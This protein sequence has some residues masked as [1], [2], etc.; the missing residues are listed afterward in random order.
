MRLV[1]I[2][3]L[4]LLIPT[5]ANAIDCDPLP[6]ADTLLRPGVIVLLGEIH[7][8]EQGP[9]LVSTLVCRTLKRGLPVNVGLEIPRI[10]AARVR[11]PEVSLRASVISI[12]PKRSIKELNISFDVPELSV[13]RTH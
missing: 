3:L 2:T 6:H 12:L 1:P 11:L 10:F 5:L 13:S 8:T 9:A 4:T 7:G